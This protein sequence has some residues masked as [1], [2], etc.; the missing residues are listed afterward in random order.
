MPKPADLKLYLL[1][2]KELGWGL[3]NHIVVRASSEREARWL[4]RTFTDRLETEESRPGYW[5]NQWLE[6]LR[7][8]CR[9]IKLEE[10]AKVILGDFRAGR[11]GV[12]EHWQPPAF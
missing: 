5:A 6:P 4:A 3:Y 7:T 8:E 11:A 1:Q 2:R 12:L 9:E 10:P